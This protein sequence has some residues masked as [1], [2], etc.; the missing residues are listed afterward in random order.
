MITPENV[1]P[2]GWTRFLLLILRDGFA[3]H[4]EDETLASPTL[5]DLTR[6]RELH[7]DVADYTVG[8]L[9]LPRLNY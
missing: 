7:V 3:L 4:S 6:R 5:P 8:S 2:G 1:Q 9:Q